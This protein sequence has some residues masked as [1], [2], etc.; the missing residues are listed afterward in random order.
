MYECIGV[1]ISLHVHG[2]L[3]AL[4]QVPHLWSSDLIV[5]GSAFDLMNIAQSVHSKFIG[6]IGVLI[7]VINLH[8]QFNQSAG[9]HQFGYAVHVDWWFIPWHV[10]FVAGGSNQV[11][12][13]TASSYSCALMH[14][15][16]LISVGSVNHY[17]I[18]DSHLCVSSITR[19]ACV[20]EYSCW[21]SLH[22]ISAMSWSFKDSLHDAIQLLYSQPCG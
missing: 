5:S 12:Q 1:Q 20:I 2:S 14:K 19:S 18:H 4:S 7:L 11:S 3:L 9:Q 17:M 16:P 8:V 10:D 6:L 21:C 22:C 13:T 15:Y